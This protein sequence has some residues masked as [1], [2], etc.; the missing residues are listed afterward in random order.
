M[1]ETLMLAIWLILMALAFPDARRAK[2]PRVKTLAALLLFVR[3]NLRE[4]A[5]R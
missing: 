2:H 5:P 1:T 4:L 3:A